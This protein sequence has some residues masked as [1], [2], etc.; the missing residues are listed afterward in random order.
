[1]VSVEI[2]GKEVKK[3]GQKSQTTSRDRG[4]AVRGADTSGG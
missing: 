2:R 3:K 1:M 4:F